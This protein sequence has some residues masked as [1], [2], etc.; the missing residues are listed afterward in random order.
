MR[1]R[2]LALR[3]REVRMSENRSHVQGYRGTKAAKAAEKLDQANEVWA[4]VE[5]ER[6]ADDERTARLRAI[7]LAR[8]R[9]AS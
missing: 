6:R 9:P 2:S 3:L 1:P 5:A 7:R 4:E 8:E